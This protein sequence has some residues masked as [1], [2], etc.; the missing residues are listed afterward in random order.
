MI[1]NLLLLL[2]CHYYH[3]HYSH[4]SFYQYIIVVFAS[5]SKDGDE[6]EAHADHIFGCDGAYSCVRKQ[7]MRKTLV[8]YSQ[9]Y[10]PHGYMELNAP[11]K[12]GTTEVGLANNQGKEYTGNLG[13]F[14]P[15]MQ[16]KKS[17]EK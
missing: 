17:P 5:Y 12:P 7:L 13:D 6:V 10:I 11:P 9:E 14:T 1:Y 2:L 8:D 15:E 16:K 3:Y 4:S